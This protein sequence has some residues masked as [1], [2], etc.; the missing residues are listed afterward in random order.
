[1][2]EREAGLFVE[3]SCLCPLC[4]RLHHNAIDPTL[5][6]Q[7]KQ[8]RQESCRNAAPPI[9]PPHRHSHDISPSGARSM[10][11]PVPTTRAPSRATRKPSPSYDIPMSSRSGLS[12][13]S[14]VPSVPPCRPVRAAGKH[15]G[16][17]DQRRQCVSRP[18]RSCQDHFSDLVRRHRRRRA[19]VPRLEPASPRQSLRHSAP[20][21]S[22]AFGALVTATTLNRDFRVGLPGFEPGTSASRTEPLAISPVLIRRGDFEECPGSGHILGPSADRSRPRNTAVLQRSAPFPRQC[23]LT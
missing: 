15:P 17:L 20:T 22:E 4:I 11:M 21:G 3:I 9:A 23:A 19:S 12:D 2:G 14:T 8:F 6:R 10:R 1:M 18:P 5:G 13:A 7:R 16:K